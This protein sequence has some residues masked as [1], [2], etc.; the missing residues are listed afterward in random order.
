MKFSARVIQ[1]WTGEIS[2]EALI[3]RSKVSFLGDIDINTGEIVGPDIDIKGEN[4]KNQVLIFI[5]GRGSTVGSNVLYGLSKKGLAPKLIGTC[6]AEP[7][8]ISG[9]IYGEVPM[10]SNL[11]E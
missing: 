7:I 10:I 5:E 11:S 9:A 6:R 2:G 3:T 4:I 8:T 1:G